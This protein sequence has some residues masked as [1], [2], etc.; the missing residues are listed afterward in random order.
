MSKIFDLE[1][2]LM[3]G[4]GKFADLIILNLITIVCCIPVFTIGAAI[5]ALHF[6]CLKMVRDE[7]TYVIKSY[8]KSFRQNFKQA[9]A[10][11][12]IELVVFGV[13]LFDIYLMGHAGITFPVW[14]PSA[15]L[16]VDALV[17]MLGIHVF[18][19]LARFENTVATTIKN[20]VMVGILTLPKTILMVIICAVPVVLIYFFEQ[21]LAPLMLLIGISGPAFMCAL[22]Y[23]K[24]FKRFEPQQEDKDPDEWFI[25]P[26]T[27]EEET[28]C[29]KDNES[30][31]GSGE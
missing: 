5:T 25:E 30:L 14:L 22:L 23:N 20:S 2:P 24:T 31:E 8:F 3:S 29:I 21:V 17:F 7:E 16:A 6:V 15:L 12:L 19:L 4:L 26:E 10:I 1:S 28:E 9:T 13:L 18:P 11:W 27:A